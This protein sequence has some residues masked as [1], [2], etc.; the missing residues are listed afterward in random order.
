[1][2]RGITCCVQL[3]GLGTWEKG[4]GTDSVR[5]ARTLSKFHSES[6]DVLDVTD[7]HSMELQL[8]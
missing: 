5:T 2:K 4:L 8:V 6:R 1:M 3:N 7:R